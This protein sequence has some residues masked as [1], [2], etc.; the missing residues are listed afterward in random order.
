MRNRVFRI[1]VPCVSEEAVSSLAE[2]LTDS[3]REGSPDK[4]MTVGISG[5]SQSGKTSLSDSL[6]KLINGALAIDGDVYQTGRELGMPVY[7]KV[8]KE[9]RKSGKF[10]MGFHHE[11]WRYGLMQE[12]VFD[13][14]GR[15]NRSGDSNAIL[16]L[17]N[18]IDVPGGK[19]S[20]SMHDKQYDITKNT[21]ILLPFMF[22]RHM[23]DCFDEMVTLG[24]RPEVSVERKLKKVPDRDPKLTEEMVLKVEHPVM[25]NQ[26][27]TYN[28]SGSI[29]LDTNDFD[30]VFTL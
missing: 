8:L 20:D 26:E 4:V 16:Y 29:C 11:V 18:V 19:H 30:G 28:V 6:V 15:F 23:A 12:Q 14:V 5:L 24:I 13:A 22:Q 25:V 9:L 7:E 21:V 10:D 3:K 1:D 2:Y 17:K 27:E